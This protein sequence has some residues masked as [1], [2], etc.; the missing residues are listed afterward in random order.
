[1]QTERRAVS[2]RSLG[3][4]AIAAGCGVLIM[5]GHGLA[6]TINVLWEGK[7][8]SPERKRVSWVSKARLRRLVV[9]YE[10]FPSQIS[11]RPGDGP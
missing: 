9:E 3:G 10:I 1:M 2:H 11:A 6:H 5:E 4:R 7:P 8:L